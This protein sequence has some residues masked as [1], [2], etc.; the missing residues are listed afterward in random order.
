MGNFMRRNMKIVTFMALLE[1]PE[2]LLESGRHHLDETA[3]IL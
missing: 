2:D 1:T 3:V